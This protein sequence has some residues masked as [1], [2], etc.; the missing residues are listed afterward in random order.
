M[1]SND[2]TFL[3]SSNQPADTSCRDFAIKTTNTFRVKLKLR[4]VGACQT[5]TGHVEVRD[6]KD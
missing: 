4:K 5:V 2:L 3:K 1:E 6:L